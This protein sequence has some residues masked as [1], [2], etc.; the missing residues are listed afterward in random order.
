MANLFEK[1]IATQPMSE[2]V[3]LPLDFISKKLEQKQLK[4]DTAKADIAAQEDSMLG[5]KFLP[6]DRERHMELQGQWDAKLDQI[7]ENAGGDYSQIQAPLD[8]WKRAMNREISYGELGFQGQNYAA[9]HSKFK[10]LDEMLTEG[11]IREGGLNRFKQSMQTHVTTST[12]AGGFSGFKGYSP[13]AEMDPLGV[14]HDTID[15]VV[16]QSDENGY[17]GR[18]RGRVLSGIN[19]L[20]RTNPNIMKSLQEQYGVSPKDP[21]NPETEVEYMNKVIEGVID[22]KEYQN[23]MKDKSVNGVDF[24]NTT[25]QHVGLPQRS[26]GNN[27]SVGNS[28]I[29]AK[30]LL[31][32]TGD[33][34]EFIASPEG[35][36]LIRALESQG[37]GK[38]PTDPTERAAWI[39]NLANKNRTVSVPID[40][41][42]APVR[43][44]VVNGKLMNPDAYHVDQEGNPVDSSVITEGKN[45]KD[46][47]VTRG[48]VPSGEY[49]GWIAIVGADGQMYL[50][51]NTSDTL[52][53]SKEYQKNQIDLVANT[54]THNKTI[55]LRG[56]GNVEGGTYEARF[57]KV[58]PE[59]REKGNID[60]TT[61]YKNGEPM[62]KYFID[63]RTK[64]P[65]ARKLIKK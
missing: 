56:Y 40:G 33:A 24:M 18:T 51:E 26:K 46:I 4:Y 6:G 49:M 60:V 52:L 17:D 7:I 57:H 44:V 9:A 63:P 53:N 32:I 12:E 58:T 11:K 1:P 15:E 29:Q 16:A 36:E 45:P 41:K 50:E 39:D 30:Q 3:G 34:D 64:L 28:M 19:N 25:L 10:K 22:A 47:A 42:M 31:G 37:E 20:M 35:K 13:S 27:K 38:M 65:V 61:L 59:E 23:K 2:F 48:M 5:L 8:Q 43:G 62:Y 55:T 14:I 21:N 54:L